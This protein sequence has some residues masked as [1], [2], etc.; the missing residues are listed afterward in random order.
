MLA[1]TPVSGTFLVTRNHRLR[2]LF[3][4][5]GRARAFV[6]L[7]SSEADELACGAAGEKLLPPPPPGAEVVDSG[8]GPANLDTVPANGSPDDAAV[9]APRR[10]PRQESRARAGVP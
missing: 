3:A 10:A 8:I 6:P 5:I 7:R 4:S 2:P 1:K 9:A